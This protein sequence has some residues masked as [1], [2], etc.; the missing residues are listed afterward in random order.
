MTDERAPEAPRDERLLSDQALADFLSR[1]LEV[2][3]MVT[4]G[5]WD[6]LVGEGQG[7][8]EYCNSA[9]G[10]ASTWPCDAKRL[11]DH[12]D[13]LTERL[14]AAEGRAQWS[15]TVPTVEG[16]YWRTPTGDAP[17]ILRVRAETLSSLAWDYPEGV[18]AGPLT[19]PARAAGEEGE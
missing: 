17:Y 7:E 5:K 13:A 10:S 18:W 4:S 15:T 12:V 6:E 1:H 11:L 3:Y 19:A 8:C 9:D 2:I 16:W 14:A